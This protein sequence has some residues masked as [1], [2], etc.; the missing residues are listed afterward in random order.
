MPAGKTY[1]YVLRSSLP[2]CLRK[3]C[4]EPPRLAQHQHALAVV[5]FKLIALSADNVLPEGEPSVFTA[6]FA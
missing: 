5:L 3:C 1:A 4:P 2:E 6:L